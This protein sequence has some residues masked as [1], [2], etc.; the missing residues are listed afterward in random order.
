MNE[1]EQAMEGGKRNKWKKQS[2]KEA[3]HN[4]QIIS[5]Q[6]KSWN[7]INKPIAEEDKQA[8]IEATEPGNPLLNPMSRLFRLVPPQPA[9]PLVMHERRQPQKMGSQR[10]RSSAR[11]TTLVARFLWNR[12]THIPCSFIAPRGAAGGTK[13]FASRLSVSP[14]RAHTLAARLLSPVPRVSDA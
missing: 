11:L 8:F 13:Q 2:W 12:P 14:M 4:L 5:L 7:Q 10:K 1:R 9:T 3:K 6:L